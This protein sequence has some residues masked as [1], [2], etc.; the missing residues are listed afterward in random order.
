MILK[1]RIVLKGNKMTWELFL[2]IFL[3]ALKDSALVF[4]FVWGKI[5]EKLNPI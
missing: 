3:D 4:A 1:L 5:K 2:E